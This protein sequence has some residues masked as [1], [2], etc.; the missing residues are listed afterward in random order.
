MGKTPLALW[1]LCH[2]T[3]GRRWTLKLAKGLGRFKSSTSESNLKL[4]RQM[5]YHDQANKHHKQALFK[6]DDL[7]WVHLRKERF[8]SK[9]KSNLMPRVDGPFKVLE[10]VNNNGY[11][12]DL[13]REYGILAPSMWQTSSFTKM[14]FLR[15]WGQISFN[16]GRMMYPWR[17]M[18]MVNSKSFPHPRKSKWST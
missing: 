3:K 13:L 4:R 12:I 1:I 18:M 11:K 15:I 8:P 2:F 6:L 14:I 17:I 5:C 9:R 7:V 10:K 16:K